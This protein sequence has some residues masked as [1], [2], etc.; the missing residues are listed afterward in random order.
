MDRMET[1]ETT[2]TTT[3]PAEEDEARAAVEPMQQEDKLKEEA[4]DRMFRRMSLAADRIVEAARQ[5]GRE[6][7]G[8]AP[9]F[10]LDL[11]QQAYVPMEE[12]RSDEEWLDKFCRRMCDDYDRIAGGDP[13]FERAVRELELETHEARFRWLQQ[14]QEKLRGL[15]TMHVVHCYPLLYNDEKRTNEASIREARPLGCGGSRAYVA[16]RLPDDATRF[17]LGYYPL[18]SEHPRASSYRVLDPES[19]ELTQEVKERIQEV[20]AKDV[21]PERCDPTVHLAPGGLGFA[22]AP[23]VWDVSEGGGAIASWCAGDRHVVLHLHCRV[24]LRVDMPELS[25]G[26]SAPALLAARQGESAPAL[27]GVAAVFNES[28]G[29]ADESATPG[30]ER[31]GEPRRVAPH[32]RVTLYCGGDRYCTATWTPEPMVDPRERSLVESARVVPRI[33]CVA[34]HESDDSLLYVGLQTGSLHA[35]RLR[36]A[37]AAAEG[38]EAP[39]LR[40]ESEGALRTYEVTPENLEF[41]RR[42]VRAPDDLWWTQGLEA[43]VA[44]SACSVDSGDQRLLLSTTSSLHLSTGAREGERFEARRQLGKTP[45][46]VHQKVPP[47]VC[48]RA[49]GNLLVCHRSNGLVAFADMVSGRPFGQYPEVSTPDLLPSLPY[50]S[51]RVFC[52]RVCCLLADGT[53]VLAVPNDAEHQRQYDETKARVLA[54]RSAARE[55]ARDKPAPQDARRAEEPK[56]GH[57]E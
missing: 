7:P 48:L 4:L 5:E 30:V 18:L 27:P 46:A 2:T 15:S 52:D 6:L 38:E 53:L 42:Q 47:M 26:G 54:E 36:Y 17:R 19:P 21:T 25:E 55:D 1:T 39:T 12:P 49:C 35:V 34:F 11:K 37:A 22:R 10:Y 14:E 16:V 50:R 13:R 23:K 43:P 33:S 9:R 20:L 32:V 51:L 31:S 44:I 8:E 29:V 40:L 24:E 41:L 28:F 56:S 45:F 3:P 57:E